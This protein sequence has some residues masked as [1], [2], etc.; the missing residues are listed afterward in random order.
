MGDIGNASAA[1]TYDQLSGVEL[2]DDYIS[3]QIGVSISP[4]ADQVHHNEMAYN[5][6]VTQSTTF[7]IVAA[8]E[9]DN[10]V[11]KDVSF[12]CVTPNNTQSGSFLPENKTPWKTSD[13]ATIWKAAG[14]LSV[15]MAVVTSLTLAL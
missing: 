5:L 8:F 3:R 6:S 1:C 9:A 2:P 11:Q 13:A 4:Y 15:W 14:G 7:A 10:V 12:V